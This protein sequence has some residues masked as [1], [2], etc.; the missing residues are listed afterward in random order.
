MCNHIHVTSYIYKY[1]AHYRQDHIS[2]EN[3]IH[4][5]S[6]PWNFFERRFY[7]LKQTPSK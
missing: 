6:I 5:H 2:T 3:D 1:K 7:I 4:G